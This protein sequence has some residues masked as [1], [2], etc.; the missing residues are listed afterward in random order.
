[1]N[2]PTS[3]TMPS[4]WWLP[5]SASLVTTAWL[6]SMQ[7]VSTPAGSMLPTAMA[8]S[9]DASDVGPHGVLG[10][11]DVGHHIGEGPIVADGAGQHERHAGPHA[12]VHHAAFEDAPLH[13]R[14]DGA[15]AAHFVNHPE[16]VRVAALDASALPDGH[17]E[18]GAEQVRL[19]VVGGEPVAGEE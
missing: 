13:A 12:F 1:M 7:Y 19:D 11:D 6:M 9:V 10:G 17:A 18:R 16:V 3:V 15:P 2:S 4:A 5:R 8:W 14:P